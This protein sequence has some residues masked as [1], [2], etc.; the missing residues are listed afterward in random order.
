LH[1]KY[2]KEVAVIIDEYDAPMHHFMSK[3]AKVQ[4]EAAKRLGDF[5]GV[6][7]PLERELRLVYITGILRLLPTSLFSKLNN[8]RDH[9]FSIRSNSVC[10]YTRE[11]IVQNFK[12][13]LNQL[14]LKMNA[15]SL[16]DAMAVLESNYNGYHFGY[17]NNIKKSLGDDIFNPFEINNCL[18]SMDLTNC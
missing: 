15:S 3:D 16:D 17:D 7:K 1:E 4:T 11:E 8:L 13:H 14:S 5:Y 9:T 12:P 18:D 2:G 6:L 10:G